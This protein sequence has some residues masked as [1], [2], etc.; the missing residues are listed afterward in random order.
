MPAGKGT[1]TRASNM[2][3]VPWSSSHSTLP[4]QEAKCISGPVVVHGS[5]RWACLAAMNAISNEP[6][7]TSPSAR[8]SSSGDR[9]SGAGSGGIGWRS[10]IRCELAGRTAPVTGNQYQSIC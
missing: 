3:D 10:K 1:L 8:S 5:P 4:R 7:T 2:G 9:R 6:R